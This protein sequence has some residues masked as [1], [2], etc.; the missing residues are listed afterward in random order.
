VGT[1][2][3]V[4]PL[5]DPLTSFEDLT[6]SFAELPFQV[7]EEGDRG[8]GEHP[9]LQLLGDRFRHKSEVS[10]VDGY[11]PRQSDYK[12]ERSFEGRKI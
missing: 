1:E 4:E 3:T 6:T 11:N 8:G 12:N 9:P 7:A 10:C 5:L 2:A